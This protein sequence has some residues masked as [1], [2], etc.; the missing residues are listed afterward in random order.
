MR[1]VHLSDLHINPFYNESNIKKVDL[2]LAAAIKM[3]F[4]HLVITGDISHDADQKSFELLR[5]MLH[6]LNLLDTKKT[7]ITIGNHDIFGGVYTAK[8]LFNFPEKCRLTNYENRVLEFVSMFEELFVDCIFPSNKTFFPYAKIINDFVL[9]GI[10]TND[11]YSVLKNPFASNGRVANGDFEKLK[12]IFEIQSVKAKR[13]IVLAHHHFY[14]NN[15]EAKSS[16][17]EIWNM[18][19][20]YTMK[21]RGKK[22]L[23]KLFKGNSVGLLLHGHSHEN[24]E[25]KR[26]G[27]PIYNSAGSIDNENE[28][29]SILNTIDISKNDIIVNQYPFHLQTQPEENLLV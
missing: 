2:V 12:S 13:K 22:K 16:T 6:N 8:D 14:K 15:F 25:Y 9:I 26:M 7:S 19:E 5:T 27:I 21:L 18:I 23:L 24:K 29:L 28:T 20:G 10:N 17:N 3:G 1:I 11:R 4:D